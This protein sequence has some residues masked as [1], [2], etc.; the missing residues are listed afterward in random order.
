MPTLVSAQTGIETSDRRPTLDPFCAFTEESLSF[1]R[2]TRDVP[3]SI[4]NI[5]DIRPVG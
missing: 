1:R 3:C 2:Y 4:R 5:A